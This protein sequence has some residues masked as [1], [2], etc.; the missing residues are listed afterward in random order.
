MFAGVGP[1]QSMLIWANWIAN[2]ETKAI[3]LDRAFTVRGI[4]FYNKTENV[5]V[6]AFL[7]TK[8]KRTN[9]MAKSHFILCA[10]F[11]PKGTEDGKHD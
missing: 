6:W 9:A 10:I 2:S 3:G 8:H 11:T 7:S 1:M 5:V 4:H